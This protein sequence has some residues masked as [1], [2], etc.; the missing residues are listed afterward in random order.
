[1]RRRSIIRRD[2]AEILLRSLRWLARDRFLLGMI[3]AV[4]LAS[5]APGVGRSGGPLH[6]DVLASAGI[7]AIFFLHGADLSIER[8]RAGVSRWRLHAFVQIFTFG[9]FPLLWVPF[10]AA[11]ARAV[12][13]DLMLGFFY[14]CAIPSTISSSVAMTAIARGNVPG[15]IFNATL[16]SILGVFLTPL[17]VSVAAGGAGA[18]LSAGEAM[19]KVAELIVVP[20]AAGQVLRP[21]LRGVLARRGGTAGALDRAIVLLIVYV[22]FCDSVLGGLWTDHG[23]ATLATT[24]AGAALFLAAVLFLTRRAAAWLGFDREDEIAAVFCGSKKS[25]G[26]GVAMAKVLFGAHPGLGVIV[27]P[28]MFYHQLQLVVCSLLAQRYARGE[29]PRDPGE[30]APG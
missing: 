28:I 7:F 24:A 6:G 4:V 21:L 25:L 17:L 23:A 15:A 2:M 8:L 5:V 10:R 9:V 19:A 14:L 30:A 18:P 27:L 13:P 11:A 26:S 3:S 12:P 16:S 20:L 22:S 29:T 1:M